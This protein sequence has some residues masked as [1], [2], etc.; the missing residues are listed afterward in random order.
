MTKYYE[1][2]P[3]RIVHGSN[4]VLTYSSSSELAVGSLVTVPV[5]KKSDIPAVVTNQVTKPKFTTRPITEQIEDRPLPISL[6]KLADWI[7]QFYATHPVTTWQTILPRGLTKKRRKKEISLSHPK[8]NRTQILLSTPQKAAIST[9]WDHPTG[10][11]IL[12]G[13][14][15]S[16][17]TQVY[18]ELA[19]KTIAENRSVIVLVPEIALTS[20][21]IA[22]FTPHFDNVTV[23]HSTMT[24]AERHNTWKNILNSDKPQVVIG[25]R[26]ALFTPVPNL[27]LVVIDECHEPT[28]KQ[29]QAP[30]YS[31]LRAAAKLC[32]FANA[33]LVLGSA[34]PNV[35]DYYLA[36]TSNRPII[37]MAKPAR[38]NVIQ[39]NIKVVDMTKKNHFGRHRFISNQLIDSINSALKQ[40]QQSLIFHNRR[41]TA[42]T[43]LC[44]NCGWNALCPHCFVPLTL[45]ADHF[46]LRCHICNFKSKVPT[47]CPECQQTDVIHKGI[48]TKLLEQELT[49]L[50]PH[51]KIARFDGDTHS[52][53]RLEKQYQAL[54]DG[55]IDIIIGTQVVAKGLDLPKLRV[56]GVVQADAGLALPDYQSAERTF[57]LTYQVCGRVGRNEHP[58]TVVVQSY[59][60]THPAVAYGISR[61]YQGFYDFAIIERQRSHFPPFRHLAKM[62]CS[63]KTE[64]SAINASQKLSRE[65]RKIAPERVEILGPS[66]AFY[67]R[68]RDS[69]RWQ[70]TIKSP[71]RSDLVDLMQHL[72]PTNWQYELDPASLL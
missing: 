22:E 68:F 69:Y 71:V 43:T 23:T 36:K 48:G 33:R 10:T 35:A 49:K 2:V 54:Y 12:H 25:P 63:Y 5:G 51:A 64:R 3:Q 38:K 11:S 20:Q 42:P 55:D 4:G 29:E 60:P 67:E 50:F 65:L 24:E 70:I 61:D 26:S 53:E 21:L 9:I 46:H 44:E 7:S 34:T 13:I 41:G 31:A 59:Q 6:V 45:H 32:E 37:E 18:I 19:L 52:D 47:N 30:R 56:V 57:Q 16:G 15:G 58:S 72:P 17:K 62:V 66:P 40:S 14:T 8:R 27:G 28:F 1:V 39:P